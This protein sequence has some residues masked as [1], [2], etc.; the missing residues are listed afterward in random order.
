MGRSLTVLVLS[1]CFKTPWT[2][3]EC[4]YKYTV[5]FSELDPTSNDHGQAPFGVSVFLE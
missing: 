1:R 2:N 5:R 4:S 3:A